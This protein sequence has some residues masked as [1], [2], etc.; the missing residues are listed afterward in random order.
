[1]ENFNLNA[2]ATPADSKVDYCE[3]VGL[4]TIDGMP[5][6]Q[7]KRPDGTLKSLKQDFF[8]ELVGKGRIEVLSDTTFKWLSSE[9]GEF[10]KS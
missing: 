7:Y 5:A 3:V 6:I 10:I 4:G 2:F 9:Q 8:Q 1:M